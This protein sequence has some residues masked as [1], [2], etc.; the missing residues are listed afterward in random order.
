[1]PSQAL[2]PLLFSAGAL[3]ALL[4]I[5]ATRAAEDA[6]RNYF[7]TLAGASNIGSADG[8]GPAAA[9]SGWF[10]FG[11]LALGVTRKLLRSSTG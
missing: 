1:M 4:W 8:T 5:T 3:A 6:P 10:M 2:R 11:L 9:P 7:S